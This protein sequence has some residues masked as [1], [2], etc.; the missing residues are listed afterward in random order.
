MIF[1]SIGLANAYPM[2]DV[3]VSR[4]RIV[5]G[6][7]AGRVSYVASVSLNLL[8]TSGSLYFGRYFATSSSSFSFP[9]STSIITATDVIGLVID[10]MLKIVS[11]VIGVRSSVLLTPNASLYRTPSL[12]TTATTTPGTSPRSV[13]VLRNEERA[14]APCCGSDGAAEATATNSGGSSMRRRF[15]DVILH[16][17]SRGTARFMIR[18]RSGAERDRRG[19]SPH[20]SQEV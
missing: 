1:D 19:P 2:P 13:A 6:R 8:M 5:I 17:H 14:A 16:R 3:C 7:F 20:S 18:S 4:W 15:M 12:S 11:F 10:A 9:S